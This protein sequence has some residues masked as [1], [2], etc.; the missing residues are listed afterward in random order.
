MQTLDQAYNYEV[1]FSMP[2]KKIREH[3]IKA[4]KGVY[5]IR[6]THAINF[7]HEKT[8][9]IQT[10]TLRVLWK[11]N[12]KGS[13]FKNIINVLSFVNHYYFMKKT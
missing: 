5:E 3:N 2:Q 6:N 1:S 12:L 11:K 7:R 10:V 8:L 9:N 4:V 13:A